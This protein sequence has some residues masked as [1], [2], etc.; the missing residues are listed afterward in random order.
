MPLHISV[1]QCGPSRSCE[2]D[3]EVNTDVRTLTWLELLLLRVRSRQLTQIK[4]H[5]EVLTSPVEIT[6]SPVL[7]WMCA[8]WKA[9]DVS[10]WHCEEPFGWFLSPRSIFL[11]A[12]S[13]STNEFF[14]SLVTDQFVSF[15]F[16]TQVIRIQSKCIEMTTELYTNWPATT[17]TLLYKLME[18]KAK[19]S[20][21]KQK[22]W[23]RWCNQHNHKRVSTGRQDMAG[24]TQCKYKFKCILTHGVVHLDE[25]P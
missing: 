16:K 5:L 4:Q 7:P 2:M 18:R 11:K 15:S 19:K 6:K 25:L 14:F 3:C 17:R 9:W 20:K 22:T 23:H 21:K 8:R 13:F 1:W 10:V 12:D 24:F